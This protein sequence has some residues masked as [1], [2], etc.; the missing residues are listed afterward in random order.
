[1]VLPGTGRSSALRRG[2]AGS[3]GDIWQIRGRGAQTRRLPTV[4][5]RWV[6]GRPPASPGVQRRGRSQMDEASVA[7]RTGVP[8][9][10]QEVLDRAGGSSCCCHRSRPGS[11]PQLVK[12]SWGVSLHCWGK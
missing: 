6:A 8:Y 2:G 3:G 10:V 11:R 4:V 9:L 1:M 7:S 12:R 5:S